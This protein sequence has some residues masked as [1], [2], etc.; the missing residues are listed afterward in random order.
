MTRCAA[1]FFFPALL[2]LGATEA[3]AAGGQDGGSA[4]AAAYPQAEGLFRQNPRWLGGDAAYS[5]GLSQD[6]ILWLFGDSFVAEKIGQRRA[7][8]RFARNSIAIQTGADPIHATMEFHW[9][10]S[11]SGAPTSY[12]G[13]RQG[14][15]LWPAGG[16]RA[17]NEALLIFLHRVERRETGLGFAI[18]GFSVAVVENADERV[19]RWRVDIHDVPRLPFDAVPAC[20]MADGRN[21][22]VAIAVRQEGTHAG[23]LMRYSAED[24]ARAEF[25]EPEWW[26]GGDGGW[27]RTAAIGPAGP[28]VIMEDAGA[29]CSLH[30]D[31]R[32]GAYVHFASYGFGASDIGVRFSPSLTGPWED[33]EIVYRPPESDAPRPFVYAAKAHAE[34]AGPSADD[35]L[36]T[37][38][39]NSFD[40]GDLLSPEGEALLYWPRYVRVRLLPKHPPAVD[41]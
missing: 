2:L 31:H 35:L 39:T 12:F 7:E 18:T 23:M 38:A 17:A 25:D 16:A 21:G 26:T 19:P 6:R 36:V 20:A 11:Q 4:R 3:S 9:G 37:Y 1:I 41:D 30:Y 10:V 28:S 8:T 34:L 29:E 24:I 40:I 33:A 22:I 15:W 27:K 5:V 32:A 14:A 13:D